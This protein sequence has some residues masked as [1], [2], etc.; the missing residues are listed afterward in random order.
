MSADI[1]SFSIIL[2]EIFS[3]LDPYPGNFERVWFAKMKK[4]KPEIPESFP[5][6]LKSLV[7]RGCSHE[8][9][10]RPGLGEFKSAFHKMLNGEATA[11][12]ENKRQNAEESNHMIA[13]LYSIISSKINKTFFF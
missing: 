13:N 11:I 9:T 2:L 10:D 8:P 4:D 3:C 6:D 5:E 12:P 7:S 1:Y